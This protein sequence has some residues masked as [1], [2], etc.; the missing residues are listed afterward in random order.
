MSDLSTSHP[1]MHEQQLSDGLVLRLAGPEHVEGLAALNGER[2]GASAGAV[3]RRL[4]RDLGPQ[5]F[6]GG[7]GGD[8]VRSPLWLVGGAVWIAG[9]ELPGGR[10]EFVATHPDYTRRG[11]IRA[12]MDA[13]HAESDRR[14]HL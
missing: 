7:L 1:L 12:Q 11:L 2:N 9:V 13:L 6:W 5:V 8:R 10:P 3:C 14:G 4:C